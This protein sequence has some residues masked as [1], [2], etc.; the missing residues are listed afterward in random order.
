MGAGRELDGKLILLVEDH[1]ETLIGLA[2]VLEGAGAVV[3]QA[4]TLRQAVEFLRL[5]FGQGTP[6]DAVVC[7][8]LLPD[9]NT[10]QIPD[11][12]RTLDSEWHG[13]LVAISAYP[14]IEASARQAGFDDFLPKLVSPI[15]PIAL[16]ELFRRKR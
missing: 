10:L 13:P 8:V 16:A 2:T 5:A 9:G 11:A 4:S 15:L 1:R 14:D 3:Q 12:L 6:P 7:D